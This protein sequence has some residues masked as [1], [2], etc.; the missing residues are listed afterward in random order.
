MADSGRFRVAVLLLV[1]VSSIVLVSLSLILYQSDAVPDRY[2][3]DDEPKLSPKARAL[4]TWLLVSVALLLVF[5]VTTALLA[6]W[7]RRVRSD[8]AHRRRE[9]TASEDVWRM[10]RLPDDREP[11]EA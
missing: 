1:I 4:Y 11:D 8:L 6:R 7:S 9:P 3:A 10:H 5:V 2:G